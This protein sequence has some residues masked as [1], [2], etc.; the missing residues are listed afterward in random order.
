MCSV[1]T[2]RQPLHVSTGSVEK[3]VVTRARSASRPGWARRIKKKSKVRARRV[4]AHVRK[5]QV[6]GNQESASRLRG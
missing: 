1:A 2:T 4:A 5:I 6:L 3:I